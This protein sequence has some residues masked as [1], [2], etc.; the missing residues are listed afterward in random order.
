MSRTQ[1]EKQIQ[2]SLNDITTTVAILLGY[3]HTQ[4]MY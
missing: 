1:L 4:I 3:C 2:I